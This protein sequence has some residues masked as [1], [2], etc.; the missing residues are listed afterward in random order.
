M[1]YSDWVQ[2]KLHQHCHT[3]R[4]AVSLPVNDAPQLLFSPVYES[5]CGI[6]YTFH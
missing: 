4:R 5:V 1:A 6:F 3:E 2:F